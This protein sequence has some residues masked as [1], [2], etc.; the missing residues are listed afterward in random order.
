[1]DYCCPSINTLTCRLAGCTSEWVRNEKC[2]TA[3][4]IN[5]LPCDSQLGSILSNPPGSLLRRRHDQN[6]FWYNALQKCLQF[7][8]FWHIL[9]ICNLFVAGH[10][11]QPPQETT[12]RHLQLST[13][14]FFSGL[15]KEDVGSVQSCPY[16][17]GFASQM[18][19]STACETLLLLLSLPP[20]PSS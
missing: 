20:S 10:I 16:S 13:R 2:P 18:T 11:C 12:I 6:Y 17:H 15:D 1:M 5:I 19:S 14:Q 7:Q 9:T 3:V 8:Q 4:K